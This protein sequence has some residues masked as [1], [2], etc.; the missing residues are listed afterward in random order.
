MDG[1]ISLR[2]SV[3]RE[4]AILKLVLNRRI[5]F[6]VTIPKEMRAAETSRRPFRFPPTLERSPP[7]RARLGPSG[8]WISPFP[9]ES[10]TRPR[11]SSS[12]MRASSR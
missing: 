4:F 9:T 7:L 10:G 1:R 11:A 12:S 6:E 3:R 2:V 8:E 5:S